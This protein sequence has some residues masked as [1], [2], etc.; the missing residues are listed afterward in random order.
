MYKLFWFL[1]YITEK[2]Y[3][4]QFCYIYEIDKNYEQ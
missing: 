4:K 2:N 1:S 3:Q